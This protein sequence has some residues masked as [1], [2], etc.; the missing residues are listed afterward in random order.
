MR[1]GDPPTRQARPRHSR[2]RADGLLRHHGKGL[3]VFAAQAIA[4]FPE[5]VVRLTELELAAFYDTHGHGHEP[6][7]M[8]DNDILRGYELIEARGIKLSDDQLKA[9]DPED[10]KPGIC[11]NPRRYWNDYKAEVDVEIR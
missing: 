10:K 3:F 11:K 1:L 7:M 8:I 4:Q 2:P 9:L 5:V 6:E